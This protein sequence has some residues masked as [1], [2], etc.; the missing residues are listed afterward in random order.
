MA[1]WIILILVGLSSA[2]PPY[3]LPVHKIPPPAWNPNH[4]QPQRHN[5]SPFQRGAVE[6]PPTTIGH[7]S[8]NLDYDEFGSR[9]Y[10]LRDAVEALPDSATLAGSSQTPEDSQR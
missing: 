4:Q 10:P 2:L 6:S 5:I 8:N 3:R 1:V 7:L 9:R